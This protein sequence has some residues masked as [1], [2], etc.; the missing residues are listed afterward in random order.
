M[1]GRESLPKCNPLREQPGFIPWTA[2][3]PPCPDEVASLIPATKTA[4][5]L[6]SLTDRFDDAMQESA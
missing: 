4:A 6:R 3:A 2:E 5:A 1:S